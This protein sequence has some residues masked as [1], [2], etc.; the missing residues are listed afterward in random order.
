MAETEKLPAR[1]ARKSVRSGIVREYTFIGKVRPGQEKAMR[2][3]MVAFLNNPRRSNTEGLKKVGIYSALHA[4]FDNDTRF[5]GTVWFDNDFDT[6]FDDVFAMVGVDLY[7]SFF[8]HAEGFPE[9]GLTGGLTGQAA[10]E[11]AKNWLASNHS[12]VISFTVT[13]PDLTV[14]EQDKAKRLLKAFNETLDHPEAEKALQHPALKP[15]L[16]LASE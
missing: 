11:F 9:K 5:I 8:R 15:L 1:V 3:D 4:L 12:E 2:E 13:N 14:K 16:D 6:Y 10:F 7:E